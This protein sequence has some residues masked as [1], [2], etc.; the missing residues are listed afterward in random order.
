MGD[1][2]FLVRVSADPAKT[3]PFTGAQEAEAR[4]YAKEHGG[5]IEE[6]PL[7]DGV[8]DWDAGTPRATAHDPEPGSV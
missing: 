6:L 4:A 8:W 1:L 7:T 5:V 2:K 3:L